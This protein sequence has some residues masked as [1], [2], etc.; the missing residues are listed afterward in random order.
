MGKE[1]GRLSVTTKGVSEVCLHLL[2]KQLIYIS[3]T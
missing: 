3:A 1:K 2:L